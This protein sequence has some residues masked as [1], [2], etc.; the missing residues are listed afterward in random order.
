MQNRAGDWLD[1]PAVPG[2]FV[3]NIGDAMMRWTNDRWISTPHRVVNPPPD[4]QGS[5]RRQSIAFFNNPNFDAVIEC[6]SA[7]RSPDTPPK[8]RPVTYGDYAEERYKQAH[9]ADKTLGLDGGA[10]A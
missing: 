7:F 9:G 8:Y 10:A 3:V 1:V 4:A 6:L 5:T 2:A